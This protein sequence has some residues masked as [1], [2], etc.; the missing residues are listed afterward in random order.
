MKRDRSDDFSF[1]LEMIEKITKGLERNNKD[2][3]TP[4]WVCDFLASLL[5]SSVE[6][7]LEPTPGAGNLVNAL[8]RA[9]K[10]VTAPDEFFDLPVTSYFDAVVMNPPF[11]PRNLCYEILFRCMEM[12]EI[13]IA[14]VPYDTLSNGF[15]RHKKIMRYGLRSIT[16]LPRSVFPGARTQICVLEMH[17]CYSGV[18]VYRTV[19]NAN[20]T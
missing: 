7:V 3:Q 4:L 16:H 15:R 17:R 6:N 9:G 5:P 14:L 13:V 19:P 12:S 8:E 10:I 2:F 1:G 20:K 18:T 11:T